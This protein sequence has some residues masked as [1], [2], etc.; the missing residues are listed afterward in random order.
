LE[1]ARQTGYWR[2][3]EACAAVMDAFHEKIRKDIQSDGF[4]GDA[5]NALSAWDKLNVADLRFRRELEASV[6]IAAPTANGTEWWTILGVA[7]SASDDVVKTAY[8]RRLQEHHPDRHSGCHPV[9][10]EIATVLSARL[11]AAYAESR[12]RASAI[13]TDH[14]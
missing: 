1:I 3:V 8:L 12:K 4:V 7:P 10:T 14:Y 6:K 11:N 13:G 2:D 9:I 5:A